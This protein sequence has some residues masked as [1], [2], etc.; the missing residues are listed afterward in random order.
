MYMNA[1]EVREFLDQNQERSLS[2]V[3]ETEELH[4]L[5][6]ALKEKEREKT[7]FDFMLEDTK[8]ERFLHG[9]L[10]P[11]FAFVFIILFVFVAFLLV[12]REKVITKTQTTHTFALSLKDYSNYRALCNP[13]K[14]GALHWIGRALNEFP[15]IPSKEQW[16]LFK[17][18]DNPKEY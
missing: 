5:A 7:S 14:K 6:K 17:D 9:F 18:F 3:F 2:E 11:I 13:P 4:K 12:P 15:R 10:Q 1:I 8:K 16:R